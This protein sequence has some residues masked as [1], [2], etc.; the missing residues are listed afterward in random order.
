[1]LRSILLVSAT[2]F[3]L[4]LNCRLYFP[5]PPQ[6]GANQSPSD[7][8]ATLQYLR[9]QIDHGAGP[10]MQALFPE[11]EFFLN[12]LYGL[13]QV[14]VGL[15]APIGSEDRRHALAEAR[16]AYAQLE[17]PNAIAPFRQGKS[18]S[19]QYGIF[20]AGWRNY[21][22][23][24][25]LLLQE[26][27]AVNQVELAQ[28]KENSEEISN[29]IGQSWSPFLEAYP[30]SA[31]PVDTF[32]AMVSLKVYGSVVDDRYEQQISNWLKETEGY[33]DPATGLIPHR[34]D[35]QTGTL[36]IGAR[37]T[38]QSLI[39]LFIR[40]LDSTVA[41]DHYNRFRE[42]FALYVYGIPGVSEYPA[43]MNGPGDVDSGP[44]IAGASLS[45]TTVMIGT[46]RA[47]GDAN[48]G[49]SIWH[50]GEMLGMP[51]RWGGEKWYAFGLLPVG[52]AFA[53]WA[54]STH[55]W[56]TPTGESFPP[57]EP[58]VPLGWRLRL[59]LLSAAPIFLLFALKILIHRF[60]YAS[61]F[62]REH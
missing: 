58:V 23:A 56:L 50:A 44:L 39:L 10:E 6:L 55:L 26:A 7:S 33:L 34:V 4:L 37:A 49:D 57:Y 46:A 18:L 29:A 9:N 59:H 36:R 20:Y 30:G 11:G 21:L 53:A 48:W 41:Q 35:P 40:E 25:I 47:Y 45:A 15:L 61:V 12:V 60:L 13:T 27:G 14:N 42:Q 19:P 17:D 38:S 2:L 52:D 54:K 31:W 28:F 43:G 16:F 8:D 1:M 32:P 24:G 51:L 3:L 5:I 62:S 22:L